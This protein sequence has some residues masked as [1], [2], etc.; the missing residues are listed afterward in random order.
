MSTKS[1]ENKS[2]FQLFYKRFF[3]DGEWSGAL[4]LGK[5]TSRSDFSKTKGNAV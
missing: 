1:H 3:Q 2:I 5:K 4:P